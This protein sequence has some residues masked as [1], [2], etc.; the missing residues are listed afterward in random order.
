MKPEPVVQKPYLRLAEERASTLSGSSAIRYA[1]FADPE[2]N[3]LFLS[4]VAAEGGGN[5]NREVV[6][7]DDIRDVV[8]IQP[9]DKPFGSKVLKACFV[10]KSNNNAPYLGA[11]LIHAGLLAPAEG[12]KHKLVVAGDWAGWQT[13]MLAR[14]GE[15]ILFPPV[16]AGAVEAAVTKAETSPSAKPGKDEKPTKKNRRGGNRLI[17][18]GGEPSSVAGEEAEHADPA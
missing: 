17:P 18:V 2:R 8:T 3:R 7:V 10:G 15:S 14:E 13:A 11:A 16:A 1:V 4:I 12:A 9:A 5:F 6:A